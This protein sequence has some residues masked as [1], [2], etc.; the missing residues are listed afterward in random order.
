VKIG[1][2]FIDIDD[3]T[4]V[5]S[6]SAIDVWMGILSST[7]IRSFTRIVDMEAVGAVRIDNYDDLAH[8]KI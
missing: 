4:F 8:G 1:C 3:L 6:S 2:T 5:S 7:P